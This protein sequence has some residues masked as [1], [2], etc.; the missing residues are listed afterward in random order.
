MSEQMKGF[1][2][3]SS[4]RGKKGSQEKKTPVSAS[5]F[6]PSSPVGSFEASE[7]RFYC[8]HTIAVHLQ[9]TEDMFIILIAKPGKQGTNIRITGPTSRERR[10]R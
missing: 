9:S 6:F 10:G 3:I 1:L 2:S 7:V 5:P 8:D 4:A